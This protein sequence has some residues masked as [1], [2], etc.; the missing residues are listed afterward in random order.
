MGNPMSEYSLKKDPL[1]ANRI[2]KLIKGLSDKSKEDRKL[3]I[4]L[5]E[6][7]RD[8][9]SEDINAQKMIIEALKLAQSSKEADIKI[10]A[11]LLKFK[12]FQKLSKDD[13]DP[14][15]KDNFFDDDDK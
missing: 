8:K 2:S 9:P 5:Y 4:E 1:T 13:E 15:E 3:S 6:K 12:E 10:L 11:L 14:K 7:Y